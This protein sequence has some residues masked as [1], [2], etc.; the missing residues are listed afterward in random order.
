MAGATINLLTG[1]VSNVSAF[2]FFN[3]PEDQ[4]CTHRSRAV[5]PDRI[6]LTFRVPFGSGPM[7]KNL[8]QMC[9]IAL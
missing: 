6:P 2:D 5:F 4:L 3:V 1:P 9:A 8:P 7:E